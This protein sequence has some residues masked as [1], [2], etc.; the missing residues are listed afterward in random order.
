[1]VLYFV[2]FNLDHW[3]CSSTEVYSYFNRQDRQ[4]STVRVEVEHLAMELPTAVTAVLQQSCQKNTACHQLWLTLPASQTL[5]LMLLQPVPAPVR[6]SH[7]QP[8]L[9]IAHHA[10]RPPWQQQQPSPALRIAGWHCSG[11]SLQ[12][13]PG[14]LG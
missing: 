5:L 2:E 4:I 6:S 14:Q 8:V 11:C 12:G 7:Q 1:M 13:L 3:V 9:Q 10:V